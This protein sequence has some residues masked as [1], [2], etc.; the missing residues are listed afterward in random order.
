MRAIDS[1]SIIHAWDNYPIDQFPRLWNWLGSQT[2]TN[3]LSIPAV[4]HSEVSHKTPECGAWLTKNGI[5]VLHPNN[6]II[7]LALTIKRALNI[8]N[9]R[10]GSGV[11]EN[12]I[13]IIATAS[14]HNL[15]LISNERV[16]TALPK[17]LGS[18]KIPA[19]CGL[20]RPPIPCIDFLTY[21]K[22][23]GAVF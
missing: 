9:D 10:Y 7:Q 6:A 5:N 21:L 20:R 23:S 19:V 4:A 18:Y 15:E 22:R 8:H 13:L 16:Q 1:S 14:A 17:N 3:L 12:D 2:N 11:G